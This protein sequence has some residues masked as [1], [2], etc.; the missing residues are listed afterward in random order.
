MAEYVLILPSTSDCPVWLCVCL[1]LSVCP[2]RPSVR[3]VCPSVC[4]CVFVCVFSYVFGVLECL[5]GELASAC[6]SVPEQSSKSFC[7]PRVCLEQ[8][9]ASTSSGHPRSEQLPCTALHLSELHLQ[10]R[11]SSGELTWSGDGSTSVGSAEIA[12]AS[13]RT[14]ARTSIKSE[15]SASMQRVSRS[16]AK[17]WTSSIFTRQHSGLPT[18]CDGNKLQI[19]PRISLQEKIFKVPR[20]SKTDVAEGLERRPP[21]L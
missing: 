17:R 4:L 11:K 6:P 7:L 18:S 20:P 15:A 9:S 5:C 8:L 1:C 16:A 3:S 21:R 13:A 10:A 2:S 14:S 19:P 12:A